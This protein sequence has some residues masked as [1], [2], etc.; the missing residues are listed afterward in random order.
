M[1]D[2]QQAL[3]RALL[4]EDDNDDDATLD[5]SAI[6]VSDARDDAPLSYSQQQLWFLQ[7][8]DPASTAYNL[9]RA[10]RIRGKLDVSA[11]RAAFAALARRHAI[12]RSTFHE[13]DGEPRQ[14]VNAAHAFMLDEVDL[15]ALAPDARE[16][17]LQ[18]HCARIATHVFDLTRAPALIACVLKLE[19]D[20]HVLAWCL[21]HIGSDAWSNPIFMRDLARAYEDITTSGAAVANEPPRRYSDFAAWQRGHAQAGGYAAHVAHWN[22]HLRADLQDLALPTDHPR[23]AVLGADGASRYVEIPA[24]LVEG[25]R[26]FCRASQCTPFVALFTAW[27]LLLARLSGQTGFAVG[28]PSANRNRPELQELLGFFVTTQVFRVNAPASASLREVCQAVRADARA[29][30]NY[31]D[32]PLELLLESRDVVRDPARSPLFQ[33]LFGLQ[34]GSAGPG[35]SL[36]GV[37]VERLPVPERSAK[38]EWSLDLLWDDAAGPVPALHG[39]LEFNTALYAEDTAA[40]MWRRYLRVLEAL[41]TPPDSRVAALD[42]ILPEERVQAQAW[43]RNAAQHD[44]RAPVYRLF[45]QQA[46]ATPDAIALV[47]GDDALCYAELNARA[48]RRAHDLIARGAGPDALVAIAVQRSVDMVVGLLAIQKAGAAYVPLDLDYPVE[49]LAYMLRDSGAMLLLCAQDLPDGLVSSDGPGVVDLRDAPPTD[50]VHDPDVTLHGENLAYVIYTSGS[51]GRPKGAA[52]RHA[53]LTNRVAWMQQA[54]GLAADDVVLQKTPFGFDVSVWEFFWPLMTGAR[55]V[56]AQPGDHRDPERLVALIHRHAVTTVHFVP[57]MLAAFM[58]Y[59]AAARCASLRRILCSGEALPAD[60]RDDV[61]QRMPWAELHNLYGPTEAAIDVTASRCAAEDGARVP[62]GAPISA[63]QAWVLDADLNLSPPGVVGELYLGGMGLARGYVRRPGMTADRFVADPYA[64]EAGGR[65]YRTGDLA[66]WRADGQL[67]YQG[68]ADHQVKIRGFRVELGEVQTRLGAQPGVAAAVAVAH[69]AASGTKLVAYVSP[70]DAA[71]Q[72]DPVTLRAALAAELPDYMV[73]AVIVVLAALPLSANGKI[74]RKALPAPDF[75]RDSEF[76]TPVGDTEHLLAGIWRDVLAVPRIGRHDNFF[77]LGGD[78]ILTLKIVA[79]ARKQGVK[80]APRD[81]MERQTIAALA[82]SASA[83]RPEMATGPARGSALL[84]PVQHTFF[85]LSVPHRSHWNQSVVL[86]PNGEV[87]V[88]AL[89]RAVDAVLAHHDAFRL[90][91]RHDMQAGWAQAY[92]KDAVAPRLALAP[93]GDGAAASFADVADALQRSLNLESGPVTA[94]AWVE[95]NAGGPDAGRPNAGRPDV[96]RP[97]RLLWVAHHLVV[98]AV[99]WRIL[100]EDLEAAYDQARRGATLTLPSATTS[101]AD[102]TQALARYGALPATQAQLPEWLAICGEQDTPLPVTRPNGGNRVSDQRSV[103]AQLDATAS[104]R[105]LSGGARAYRAQASELLLTAVARVLC[106]WTGQESVL[107]ELEGHG[108][109]EDATGVDAGRVVGWFTSLF[110]LRL[111]PGA[112]DLGRALAAVKEQVRA[113]PDKGLGYGVLRTMTDSGRVLAN[114]PYPRITFNYLG[115]TDAAARTWTWDN[116]PAGVERDPDSERRSVLDIGVA[117]RDG[118]LRFT[119]SYSAAMQDESEVR[120]LADA[121]VAE[122]ARLA[123]VVDAHGAGGVTPSDFPLAALSQAQLNRLAPNPRDVADIYPPT[124]MQQGLLLHTLMNPGSGMYLMQDRYRFDRHLDLDAARRAWG[125][126]AQRHEALR[127]GFA[128]QAGETPLQVIRREVETP[129]QVFDWRELPVEAALAQLDRLLQDELAAGFEMGAAPLWRVR[130]ARL[131]DGDRM[132]L[133]YHHILM[134][135]WCRSLLLA[136]FFAAYD[137]YAQGQAPQL[138]QPVPYRDFIAWLGR[139]DMTAAQAYW[140]DTLRGFGTV[141]PLPLAGRGAPTPGQSRTADAVVSLTPAETTA[142]QR[143]A[144]QQQLTVNT[145]AQG[146]WALWLARVAG[147][148]DVLYGVTVA[149]RPTDLNGVQ[150]TIGL[151]INTLPL[152]VDVP[153]PDSPISVAQWL[154]TVQAGN[155]ALREHEHLSLA[156]I[157]ALADVPRGTTLFD[158]LFVFEN[159]PVDGALLARAKAIGARADGARTHTNYPLTVVVKP[160]E[161]LVLQLTYDADLFDEASILRVLDGLR[162][163]LGQFAGR[164]ASPLA[165]IGLLPDDEHARVLALGQGA[166]PGYPLDAGYAGLF[167]AQSR[168]HAQR[169]AARD[170]NGDIRYDALNRLANRHAHAFRASGVGRDD[171]VVV[172]AERGIG[173]LAAVLGAFK[174]NAA[175]LALDPA[176]PSQRLAQIL[177]LCRARAVVTDRGAAAAHADVIAALP[178]AVARHDIDIPASRHD[179]DLREPAHR[180]QA[181]YVIFTSGSTGTPKGVVVTSQG[182]LNNQLSKIPALGLT[183]HDV[184]GQTAAQSFDISVWQLLAGLLCGACVEIVADS[185]ARDPQALIRRVNDS[186]ITVLEC[187]PTLIQGMLMADAVSMPGL[188]WMLPTGEASSVALARAWLERYPG[189]PLVNAYGPAECADDVA[190]Y[191]VDDAKDEPGPVLAI[192]TAADHTR[193]YVLDANLDLLPAGAIGELC[194]AGVGVGRGYLHQPGLAAEQYIADP[195]AAR[196]GSRLYRTGDLARYRTDGVLEYVGRSDH[197]VKVHGFRIELGEIDALLARLTSVRQA[198]TVARDDG[199]G[200]RLV[201]YVAPRNPALAGPRDD[202]QRAWLDSV[203]AEL[204]SALP[205]YMVPAVWVVLPSIP[206]TPNGKVDRRALPAPDAQAS[207]RHYAAPEG[208]LE[209]QLADIWAAV[210]G[211]PRVGRDD[212]FFE[213]GGHSLLVMRV[214]ARIRTDLHIETPLAALFEAQTLARFAERVAEAAQAGIGQAD[215]MRSIDAFIDTLE[216]Q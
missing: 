32:L 87:D 91:Y 20:H 182:M 42:V 102:W 17:A 184:I 114:H 82:C 56:M 41:V 179:A 55:L 145:Y 45:E 81:V 14:R 138:A 12:L 13:Q 198:V 3:L 147:L 183:E 97:G 136:D 110:P 107:L 22:A 204:A 193:L 89:Q 6:P 216:I 1:S 93:S 39:R 101:F 133:S 66:S 103:S 57:S 34:V 83:I 80:I 26:A 76:E 70:R 47:C 160:G 24:A 117:L 212:S 11:L 46:R 140:R 51:T 44:E 25:L 131:A 9:P 129:V 111:R 153:G 16:A 36:P 7:K 127:A 94:A 60:V 205:A 190:L 188:R 84:S 49:R 120:A 214:V 169:I 86:R 43:S 176:L 211:V 109:E 67:L 181:A 192:G 215:A 5:A 141:T 173:M 61:L 185:V 62:I 171:V 35:L 88:A 158:T 174:A 195:Y 59:E 154:R 72:P 172:L 156:E 48:N 50:A 130:L 105:L 95:P 187:V 207:L 150:D 201:G 119:W 77:E 58:A 23:P 85:A 113:V 116:E 96:G 175:Y 126:M 54:Y 37:Q 199:Q 142:L 148:H 21:H 124:P 170:A 137:A 210:L 53:A 112:A 92:D 4:A 40:R 65:L 149:G 27:Q 143:A 19:R 38:F 135:A 191:R 29:A 208:D 178:A 123:D 90:R 196:P 144:Q 68:R 152:R 73:P 189:V 213:L 139:Q 134:D 132:V 100:L 108:R 203:Q 157:Q 162:H 31:A 52:N 121:C 186:G 125:L 64:S 71:Q 79:A 69:E 128:W 209:P 151:F 161:Q 2:T 194:V 200:R 122:L 146:A 159:A 166:T 8:L 164:P 33:V 197:Q 63:T 10:L 180:D 202:T 15:S 30:M 115:R 177:D 106:A 118:A 104:A 18:T 168:Q 163:V 98:D 74:D 206:L 155:A 165:Q 78:S 75:Q 99:S 28:V 167:E